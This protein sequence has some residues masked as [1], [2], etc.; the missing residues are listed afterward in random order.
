MTSRVFTRMY[1]D[2][3]PILIICHIEKSKKKN[4]ICQRDYFYK[5]QYF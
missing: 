3:S 4:Y 1:Y 5:I 2:I